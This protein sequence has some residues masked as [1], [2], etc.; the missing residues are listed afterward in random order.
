MTD[1][2]AAF[3]RI[4]ALAR[5]Y[6]SSRADYLTQTSKTGKSWS[7]QTEYSV[8][9]EISRGQLVK[10]A[11]SLSAPDFAEFFVHVMA[12][13]HGPAG[14]AAFRTRRVIDAI[15]E[16]AGE[17]EDPLASWMSELCKVATLGPRESFDFLSGDGHVKFLGPAFSTKLLYFTSPVGE[18]LPIFDSMVSRWL[19]NCGVADDSR[20]LEASHDN[21]GDYLKYIDFCNSAGARIREMLPDPERS[22]RGFIEY[23]IFNDQMKSDVTDVLPEW[24]KSFNP[25]EEP[26]RRVE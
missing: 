7:N 18:R 13:G 2:A 17:T 14:Y 15:C 11:R 10:S 20:P 3:F 12:W 24:I 4:E 8:P 22:D 23:L 19:W 1:F 16:F 9:S 5:H 25:A 26:S 21:F 6:V